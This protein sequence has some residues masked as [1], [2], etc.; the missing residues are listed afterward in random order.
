MK[1]KE[2]IQNIIITTGCVSLLVDSEYN[3]ALSHALFY[4][5]TV[6]Q[7]IEKGH[8]HGKLFPMAL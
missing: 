8:L 2:T 7:H 6:R 3:S 1:L 4:G 5:L